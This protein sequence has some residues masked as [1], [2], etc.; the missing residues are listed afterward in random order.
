MS[1]LIPFARSYAGLHYLSVYR[2]SAERMRTFPRA[3]HVVSMI[4]CWCSDHWRL[5]RVGAEAKPCRHIGLSRTATVLPWPS[6]FSPSYMKF[7]TGSSRN[8]IVAVAAGN[9]AL[10]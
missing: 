6:G 5:D 2:A 10:L 1:E 8:I 7:G 9:Q 4:I 3:Q